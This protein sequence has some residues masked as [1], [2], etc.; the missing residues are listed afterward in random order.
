MTS[1]IL[2]KSKTEFRSIQT[3]EP[4]WLYD[5]RQA[6]WNTYMDTPLPDRVHHLWKYT[7]PKVFQPASPVELSNILPVISEEGDEVRELPAQFSAFGYNRGDRKVFSVL[8]DDARDKGIVVMDLSVAAV[9]HKKLVQKHLASLVNADFGKFES[10]NLAVWNTG[11]FIYVPDNTILEKPIYLHR[12]PTGLH[13]Y[14]RLLVVGGDNSQFSVVNDYSCHCENEGA[15]VNG[16]NEVVVGKSSNVELMNL[17]RVPRT[18]KTFITNRNKIDADTKLN[19]Y[20]LSIGSETSKV[21]IGTQLAGRGAESRWHGILYGKDNQHFDHHTRHEHTAGNTW[22]NL[23]FKVALKDKSVSSYTGLIRI[24]E[25]A[26]NCEAYQEN[27][28]L[29]LNDGTKAESIPELEIINDE[30]SCS[31]GVTVGKVDPEMI[32]YL[33]SRGIDSAQA[34]RMVVAGFYQPVL[35]KLP[36]NV[37]DLYTVQLHKQMEQL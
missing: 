17:Q 29:L 8:S 28:N 19:A 14:T 22:S 5:L 12:H 23:E 2:E 37:R 6:A 26:S 32:Y 20:A 27:R 7:D 33:N 9:E 15:I 13:T 34:L 21:D 3:G 4:G 36:E 10:L 25:N 24:E 16:V 35:D 18:H 30:V 11:I 31:H 1:D